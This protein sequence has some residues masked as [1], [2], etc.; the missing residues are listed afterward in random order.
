MSSSK[1]KIY[2][3]PIFTD[4]FPTESDFMTAISESKI[5]VLVSEE[6]KRLT[7][8]LLYAKHGN[9]PISSSDVNQWRY[10]LF[11][12]MFQYGPTW[13]KRMDIQK[14]LRAM[15]EE[16]LMRGSKTIR[17]H[18]YN[19]STDPGTAYEDELPYMDDQSTA[20][21]KR[22][23]LEA[24]SML[25]GILDEDVTGDYLRIFDKLFYRVVGPTYPVLFPEV[26]DDEEE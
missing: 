26:G 16:D 19:P 21:Y 11:T 22:S 3:T 18:A 7:Y 2:D 1:P 14:N 5:N 10:K 9:D 25:M 12:A 20:Q 4:V 13:E 24:Y 6:G 17:N 8:Y 23:K 15:S